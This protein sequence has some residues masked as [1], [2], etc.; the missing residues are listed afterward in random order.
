MSSSDFLEQLASSSSK[1][2]NPGM[3]LLFRNYS[4]L[5]ANLHQFKLPSAEIVSQ[6]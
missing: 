2:T 5:D 1:D 6:V 4:P 3:S